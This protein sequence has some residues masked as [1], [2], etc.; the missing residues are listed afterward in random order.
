MS[1]RQGV[2]HPFD[3]YDIHQNH[4]RACC[5]QSCDSKHFLLA[6]VLMYLL[7]LLFRPGLPCCIATHTSFRS[8][9]HLHIVLNRS[10]DTDVPR[11]LV[12]RCSSVSGRKPFA[13][14]I[15]FCWMG[16]FVWPWCNTRCRLLNAWIDC[17]N[18][19]PSFCLLRPVRWKS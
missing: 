13:H 2:L 18:M 4:C 12:G 16:H 3:F 5:V 19:P 8:S 17:C 11:P 9:L 7:P 10:R 14:R 15:I 6:E 1:E